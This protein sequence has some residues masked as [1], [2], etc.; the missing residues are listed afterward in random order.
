MFPFKS[1]VDFLEYIKAMDLQGEKCPLVNSIDLISSK[2]ALK[3]I[4]QLLKHD[5]LRFGMLK[6]SLPG[7]TNTVLT[8]TLKKFEQVGIVKRT[9]LNEIPP[10][11]EYSLTDSGKTLIHVFF[12][13][14]KWGES[15]LNE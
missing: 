5:T 9:Q 12:E 13:L 3:L 2:W 15:S 1:E 6:K 7:I 11:V 10:H 14:A 8:S 4:F